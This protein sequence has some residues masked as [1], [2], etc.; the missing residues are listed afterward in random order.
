VSCPPALPQSLGRGSS[1][2]SLL[3]EQ[4]PREM[5]REQRPQ[6]EQRGAWQDRL[7]ATAL[8]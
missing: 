8:P 5:Q 2:R 7:R 1:W 4:P 3:R 6:Q